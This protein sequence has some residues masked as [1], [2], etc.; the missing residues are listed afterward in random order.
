MAPETENKLEYDLVRRAKKGDRS[1][2]SKLVELYQDRVYSLAWKTIGDR[3]IAQDVAQDSFVRAWRALPGFKGES[4][5]SSWLYRITYNTSLSE[6]RRLGKPV[7]QY[8]GDEL[9]ALPNLVMHTVSIESNL[10]KNDLVE[11]LIDALP[12][13][14]RSIVSLFYLHE[15][16]C[17]EISDVSGHPVGTVKAYLHRARNHLRKSAAELLQAG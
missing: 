8:S 2:F 6:L 1:A 13:N 3:E 5:F 7:D 10:E 14:Y 4:K 15:L 9:E 16:S 11:R 17:Q 12:P